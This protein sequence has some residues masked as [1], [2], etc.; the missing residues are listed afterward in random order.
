MTSSRPLCKPTT[1]RTVPNIE[2]SV[3][4]SVALAPVALAVVPPSVV[5]LDFALGP[6]FGVVLGVRQL[7]LGGQNQQILHNSTTSIIP[8]WYSCSMLV[9]KLL[10]ICQI[11][12]SNLSENFQL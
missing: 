11:S 4:E 6:S 2:V 5:A 3:P 9:P 7:E 12:V 8:I 10:E 1:I